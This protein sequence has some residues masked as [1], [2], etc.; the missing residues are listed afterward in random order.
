[1][2]SPGAIRVGAIALVAMLIVSLFVWISSRKRSPIF[3]IY[4][5]QGS[6]AAAIEN[7]P[8]APQIRAECDAV[9]RE[10]E[11]RLR[12]DLPFAFDIPDCKGIHLLIDGGTG[13]NP[14]ATNELLAQV[15]RRDYWMLRLRN[16]S[17]ALFRGDRTAP[18]AESVD[19]NSHFCERFRNNGQI[20]VYE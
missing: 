4:D 14:P 7:Y 8:C 1:M 2:R 16:G 19:P 11:S 3:V 10:E 15:R 20:V 17:L 9:S 18:V 6:I 13:Q 5:E 12:H